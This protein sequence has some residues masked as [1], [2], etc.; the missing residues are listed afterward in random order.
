VTVSLTDAATKKAWQVYRP[1][2]EEGAAAA[3]N[4]TADELRLLIGF[5]RAGRE[6]QER[7]Q[8]RIQRLK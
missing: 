4:Y 8:A 5:L 6:F 1:I 2:A 7:H 3:V